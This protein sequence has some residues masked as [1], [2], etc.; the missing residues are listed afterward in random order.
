MLTYDN[1]KSNDSFQMMLTY[2]KKLKAMTALKNYRK[3]GMKKC[4]LGL[5]L[6]V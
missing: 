1:I 2:E 3:I 6:V 4:T 5:T